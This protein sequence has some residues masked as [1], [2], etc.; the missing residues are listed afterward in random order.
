[1][2]N[3]HNINILSDR[4]YIA[5]TVCIKWRE[6][7][8]LQHNSIQRGSDGPVCESLQSKRTQIASLYVFRCQDRIRGQGLYKLNKLR[9]S[10]QHAL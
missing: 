10:K 5:P 7:V 2:L 6:T 4:I 9:P 1:M 3:S 8:Q